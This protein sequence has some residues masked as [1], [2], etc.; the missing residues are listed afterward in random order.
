MSGVMLRVLRSA[1]FTDYEVEPSPGMT[2]LDALEVIRRSR[3]PGLR[4]RHSCHHGSCGTCAALVNGKERL[5]CVTPLAEAGPG[6]VTVEPL[7]KMGLIGDL[8]VDPSRFFGEMPRETSYLKSDGRGTQL[9]ACIECGICVSACPV[10]APFSGPAALAAVDAD[11]EKDPARL[12]ASLL[13][14]AGPRG[15]AACESAFE[16]SRA[17]PQAV[18]PGRRIAALRRVLQERAAQGAGLPPEG[19]E[20]SQG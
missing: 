7:R 1:G 8:A 2:V 9:E 11:R 13:F 18:A 14:A 4:Y 3:E 15:V 19:P 16:C 10:T 17:C 12:D 5:L 6:P 20:A